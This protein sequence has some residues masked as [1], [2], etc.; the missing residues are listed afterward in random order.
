MQIN[1][2]NVLL[3][4]KMKSSNFVLKALDINVFD[5]VDGNAKPDTL[6]SDYFYLQRLD[7]YSLKVLNQQSA[8]L[9]KA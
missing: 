6:K 4:K 3:S 2:I 8:K 1:H 7:E 9:N 5:I